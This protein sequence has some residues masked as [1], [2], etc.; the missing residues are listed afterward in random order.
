MRAHFS[1]LVLAVFAGAS[2]ITVPALAGYTQPP[3][4]TVVKRDQFM[5]VCPI[6][7]KINW[8][9]D[10]KLHIWEEFAVGYLTDTK[11][12]HVLHLFQ[13]EWRYQKILGIPTPIKISPGWKDC[14][15]VDPCWPSSGFSITA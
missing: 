5:T 1:V 11:M 3:H 15:K 13:H 10:A 14:D 8:H 12:P 4:P 6:S 2:L 7:N 9:D